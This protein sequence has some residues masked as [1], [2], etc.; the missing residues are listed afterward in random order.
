MN[1]LRAP[2]CEVK[3]KQ[4]RMKSGHQVNVSLCPAWLGTISCAVYFQLSPPK[5]GEDSAKTQA[6]SLR[7]KSIRYRQTNKICD[8]VSTK[9]VAMRMD[10]SDDSKRSA[11]NFQN[12]TKA[13]WTPIDSFVPAEW[14][15]EKNRWT[16]HIRS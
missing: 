2:S 3:L 4:S 5:D 14:H 10:D 16:E 12:N 15:L 1:L 13:S 11:P 8:V 9:T 6:P 7:Q